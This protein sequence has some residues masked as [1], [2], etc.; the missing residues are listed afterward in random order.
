MKLS[1]RFWPNGLLL[2]LVINRRFWFWSQYIVAIFVSDLAQTWQ[3]S[4]PRS[5]S[6]CS[7]LLRRYCTLFQRLPIGL[8]AVSDV[9]IVSKEISNSG[10]FIVSKLMSSLHVQDIV[11]KNSL[12][13][14]CSR[15]HQSFTKQDHFKVEWR[16]GCA[17]H[18]RW[19][20]QVGTAL[21]TLLQQPELLPK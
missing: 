1:R 11:E 7:T 13:N 12:E 18:I 4:R 3:L 10:I 14:L 16:C 21:V 6:A 5:W 15:L 20:L 2:Q 9:L 8:E 17:P 19:N